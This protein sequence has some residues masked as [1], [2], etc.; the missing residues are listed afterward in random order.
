MNNNIINSDQINGNNYHKQ[1]EKLSGTGVIG[2]FSGRPIVENGELTNENLLKTL[3]DKLINWIKG[4][5]DLPS[6]ELKQKTVEF[7]N[8]GIKGENPWITDKDV[9]IIRAL[10]VRA[11]IIDQSEEIVLTSAKTL[12]NTLNEKVNDVFSNLVQN[13]FSNKESIKLKE[14]TITKQSNTAPLSQLIF[15]GLEIVESTIPQSNPQQSEIVPAPSLS[16]ISE[17]DQITQKQK[18]IKTEMV[19]PKKTLQP[20]EVIL[21]TL[22]SS[23]PQESRLLSLPQSI[24]SAS[25][26]TIKILKGKVKKITISQKIETKK[27][28]ASIFF[29]QMIKTGK[30]ALPYIAV[31]GFIAFLFFSVSS[32]IGGEVGVSGENTGSLNTDEGSLVAIDSSLGKPPTTFPDMK[33]IPT[34]LGQIGPARI[35]FDKSVPIP[36]NDFAL[37]KYIPF[38][39]I[40]PEEAYFKTLLEEFIPQSSLIPQ[41]EITDL[42]VSQEM[43]DPIYEPSFQSQFGF[44]PIKLFRKKTILDLPNS[45]TEYLTKSVDEKTAL[46]TPL[47]IGRTSTNPHRKALS[48]EEAMLLL[49]L[50]KDEIVSETPPPSSYKPEQTSGTKRPIQETNPEYSSSFTA[51]RVASL[52]AIGG[53]GTSLYR[54]QSPKETEGGLLNEQ[55]RKPPKWRSGNDV[56]L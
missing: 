18:A 8:T 7:L 37:T 32:N 49:N 24:S 50:S 39:G 29:Q 31:I 43:R 16:F 4:T 27:E 38:P 42:I 48:V 25:E 35:S 44:D 22:S 10:A 55:T 46:T 56:T 14:S 33:P 20:L 17:Q 34:E 45:F 9:Q 21:T 19:Q 51:G 40:K 3:R 36:G 41:K 12:I 52:M 11:G 15:T 28:N 47:L 30:A 23:S 1:L 2:F 26:Q 6:H 54:K 13:Q 5:K 53:L